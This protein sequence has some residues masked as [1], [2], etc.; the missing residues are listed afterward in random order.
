MTTYVAE[1]ARGSQ[2]SVTP[3]EANK[4]TTVRGYVAIGTVALAAGDHLEMVKLPAGCVI[5]MLKVDA[6]QADSGAA[7]AFDFGLLTGESGDSTNART[8]GNE[9]GNQI[10]IGRV[11]GETVISNRAITRLVPQPTERSVALTVT[12]GAGTAV[13]Q[14]GALTRDRSNWQRNTDYIVGD[15]VKIAG[16]AFMRATTPGTSQSG[17]DSQG[18]MQRQSPDWKIGFGL[19]T[20]DGTVVWT[21]ISPV[22]GLTM[23]YR[24]SRNQY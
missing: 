23:Q 11:A 7:L 24:P 4:T 8:N 17:T 19:T 21:C 20:N 18:K 6:D 16:G 12:A 2:P 3:Y 13:L 5:D 9:F 15:Y 1:N 10:A 14:T 22:I